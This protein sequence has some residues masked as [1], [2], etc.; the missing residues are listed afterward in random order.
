M[1]FLDKHYHNIEYFTT[2]KHIVKIEVLIYGLR[3]GGLFRVK[4][5]VILLVET[6]STQSIY[7]A[8]H[9]NS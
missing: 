2:L 8:C 9:M 3:I 4:T 6:N 5:S 1:K 7:N